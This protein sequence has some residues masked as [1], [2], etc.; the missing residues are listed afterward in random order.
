MLTKLIDSGRPISGPGGVQET[1]FG[2][3]AFSRFVCNTIDE[4]EDA[5]RQGGFGFDVVVIGS[6]M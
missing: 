3:D 6:G 4:V 1:T 5:Q 2:L